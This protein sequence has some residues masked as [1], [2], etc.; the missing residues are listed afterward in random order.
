M[1]P[2]T[3]PA[4][5]AVARAEFAKYHRLATGTDAPEELVSFAVDPSVSETGNDAYAIVSS[6]GGAT[7]TG[8]NPRSVLYGVYD[9]LAR[10]GA[11][12]STFP[13]WTSTRSPAS[14]TAPSATS[15]TAG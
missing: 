5:L 12:R 15:P 2:S 4:P 8:S 3:D 10:R 7:V 9:L 6:G 1:E 14:A 13:G 11:R